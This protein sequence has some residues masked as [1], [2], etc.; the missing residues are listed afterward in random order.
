MHRVIV[1]YQFQC[2]QSTRVESA[3]MVQSQTCEYLSSGFQRLCVQ[4]WYGR[5]GHIT[6]ETAL[7]EVD[8]L[9]VARMLN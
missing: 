6:L 8:E 3:L 5:L 1:G 7:P 9:I 4:I 2:N